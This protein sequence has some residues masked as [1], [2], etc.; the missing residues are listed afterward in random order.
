[1]NVVKHPK[2]GKS[3]WKGKKFMTARVKE[4]DIVSFP[5]SLFLRKLFVCGC[6]YSERD[7]SLVHR[8]GIFVVLALF[9][10]FSF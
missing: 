1:M 10:S 6:E 4:P 5:L 3:L 8:V 2:P 9:T 7:D